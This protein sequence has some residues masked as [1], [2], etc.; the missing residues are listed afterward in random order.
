[1][2]H[3]IP[4]F[5][6]GVEEAI[7]LLLEKESINLHIR[8]NR[9]RTVLHKITGVALANF[10]TEQETGRYVNC[11]KILLTWMANNSVDL[12]NAKD[13]FG[14]TSLHHTI[15]FGNLQIQNLSIQLCLQFKKKT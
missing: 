2:S 15:Y 14:F 9:E 10:C 8:D 5:L 13:K 3:F 1:M 4:Y 12:I 7:I 11:L 6:S